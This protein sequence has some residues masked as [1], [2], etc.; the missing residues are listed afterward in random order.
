MPISEEVGIFYL[1]PNPDFKVSLIVGRIAM[2][3]YKQRRI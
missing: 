3:P 2:R 1:I